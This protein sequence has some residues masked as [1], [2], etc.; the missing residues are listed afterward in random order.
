M[1][2]AF[3]NGVNR[4]KSCWN[5][6]LFLFFPSFIISLILSWRHLW[7]VVWN[8]TN[9]HL[10]NAFVSKFY[11]VLKWSISWLTEN[12][13]VS[14]SFIQIR[15]KYIPKIEPMQI[16][17]KTCLVGV[18]LRFFL[19][20]E[21]T[22]AVPYCTS[23]LGLVLDSRYEALKTVWVTEVLYCFPHADITTVFSSM[24]FFLCLLRVLCTADAIPA[25][26]TRFSHSCHTCGASQITYATFLCSVH[27]NQSGN[28]YTW[29]PM[30]NKT[31]CYVLVCFLTKAEWEYVF[32]IGNSLKSTALGIKFPALK[33]F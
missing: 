32:R 25:H 23:L 15:F 24:L 13:A 14:N 27:L 33:T 20:R 12:P 30:E 21:W 16:W 11:V 26:C 6:L 5:S 7:H 9:F 29:S 22:S 4:S 17:G 28:I 3:T 10:D 31:W 8:Q 1:E 18:V 2:M 19:S